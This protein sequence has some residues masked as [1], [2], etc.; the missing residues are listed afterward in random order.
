MNLFVEYFFKVTS[1]FHW[2]NYF[3]ERKRA[4][5]DSRASVLALHG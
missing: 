4:L 2:K 5:V 3:T 1:L